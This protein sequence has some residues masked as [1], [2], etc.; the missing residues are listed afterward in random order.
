[1]LRKIGLI[2]LSLIIA[3]ALLIARTGT[4]SAAGETV[5][6]WLTTPDQANLLTQ[7]NNL[8]F[9]SNGSNPITITVNSGT[10]YQQMDGWG[11]AFT[12]SSAYLVWNKLSSSTRNTLMN[13]LF[14]TS[15]GIGLSFLRQPMGASDFSS[16]GNYSYDDGSADPSLSRFSISHDTAYIIPVLKQAMGINSSI[17]IVATPWSP[18]GWMKTSGSMIGGNLLSSQYSDALANYF[19]KFIQAYQAQGVPVYGITVQNE[20]LYQP[21]GYPG[22]GMAAA[23]QGGF[24]GYNLGPALANAGLSTKI[25]VYDHNWDRI[26]YPTTVYQNSAAYGYVAGVGWHCY[27]G[28][29]SAESSFH[30]SYP[31]KDTWLTEC[32]GGDWSPGFAT[33]LQSETESLVILNA[34]YWGKGAILWNMALDTNHGPTNGGCTNCRGIVTIDQNAGTYSRTIDYYVLGHASKFVRSGAYRIDSNTFGNNSIED[35]AFQNPDGSIVVLA[36][37]N[38]SAAQNFN[39]AWNGQSVNYTLAAGAVATFKWTPGT[40]AG[41]G[42]PFSGSAYT[43]PGKVETENYN[44]G[45]EGAAYHDSDATNNGGQY[46]PNDGVDIEATTDTGGGYDVGWTAAGEW[47]KYTVNVASS[48]SYAFDFRVASAQTGGA[49]HLEVDNANVTGALTVPNTGGW[50][51]WTDVVK[52]GVN[53]SAGQH[54]FKLVTDAAGGNYNWFNV[55][56]TTPTATPTFVPPT[57]TATA[58][59]SG[60]SPTTWYQVANQGNGLCADDQNGSTANG[61]VVQQWTCSSSN[62]NQ[63]WQFR[64]TSSGYYEVVNENGSNLAWDVTNV[65]TADGALIQLW[66]YGGGNNQQ[67]QPVALDSTHY[68]FVNR[69]SGKCLDVPSASTTNG[70]QLQQYTCN[71]TSAQSWSLVP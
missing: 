56:G 20:P 13:D 43:I 32:S 16:I 45:G 19:V 65:S 71:G 62:N 58:T 21:T 26:D 46:R 18:P 11:A 12:D 27:G 38:N 33:N 15:S 53:L 25:I 34:R 59:P 67:W 52:T 60:I 31:A 66:T 68:K 1:M 63:R 24:I 41:D 47:T 42:T 22:M 17:K 14:N 39:I 40:T 50:Q 70:V 35:V 6:V 69:N 5:S 2:F 10:K 28:D 36:L 44:N 61:A 23:D 30:N 3:S 29:V 7:Q 37:N 9:G 49:F 51:T 4:A 55:T 48:G 8:T 64:S 57:A 54:V